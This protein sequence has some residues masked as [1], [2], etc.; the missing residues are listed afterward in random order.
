MS[1]AADQAFSRRTPLNFLALFFT[2][3]NSS[4][5]LSPL[6]SVMTKRK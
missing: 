6:V 5:V 4:D 3:M 1:D 2:A